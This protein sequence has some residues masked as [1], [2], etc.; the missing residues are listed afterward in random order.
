MSRSSSRRV[1]IVH[2]FVFPFSVVPLL[3]HI[4]GVKVVVLGDSGI[5]GWLIGFESGDCVGEV[6][7]LRR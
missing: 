1:G 3:E 7:I 5:V 6:S 4:Q 2:L